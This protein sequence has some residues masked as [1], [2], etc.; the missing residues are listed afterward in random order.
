MFVF[1]LPRTVV[2]CRFAIASGPIDFR[3]RAR[4]K[5]KSSAYTCVQIRI[6]QLLVYIFSKSKMQKLKE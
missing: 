1:K 3:R 5:A 4:R 6:S 2:R